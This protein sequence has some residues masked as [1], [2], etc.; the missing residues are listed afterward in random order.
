MQLSSRRLTKLKG[1]V[2]G[3]N[4]VMAERSCSSARQS[5]PIF[6]KEVAMLKTLVLIA[7]LL[8][9]GVALAGSQNF[10]KTMDCHNCNN[11]WVLNKYECDCGD[12][13]CEDCYYFG[14]CPHC[15]VL[16]NNKIV[17]PI[18]TRKTAYGVLE[19]DY[20][21]WRGERLNGLDTLNPSGWLVPSF[22]K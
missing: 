2:A 22:K 7:S 3:S 12:V 13:D 4:P 21:N 19:Q 20:D 1:K 18:G 5:S 17:L 10:H 9:S 8:L 11:G 14:E 6:T 15:G 16:R